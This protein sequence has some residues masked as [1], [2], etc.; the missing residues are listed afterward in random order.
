MNANTE[1]WAMDF[2]LTDQCK[3]CLQVCDDH[4][5]YACCYDYREFP[6]AKKCIA[7]VPNELA[8]GG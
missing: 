5:M 4:G 8:E 1:G 7:Y 2:E 6:S 3:D